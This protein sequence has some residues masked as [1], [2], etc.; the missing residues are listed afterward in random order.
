MSV[1][2]GGALV[3]CELDTNR[4]D[5]AFLNVVATDRREWAPKPANRVCS[6]PWEAKGR[7]THEAGDE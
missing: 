5:C 6:E 7:V 1:C 4:D 3:K 2:L